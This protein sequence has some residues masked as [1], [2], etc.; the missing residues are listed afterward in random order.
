MTT[1]VFQQYPST[2]FG[3]DSMFLVITRVNLEN[4]HKLKLEKKKKKN[5]L[6]SSCCPKPKTELACAVQVVAA[7]GRSILEEFGEPNYLL[8]GGLVTCLDLGNGTKAN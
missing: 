8:R 7:Q 6:D 1:E 3:G 4:A 2:L 5:K